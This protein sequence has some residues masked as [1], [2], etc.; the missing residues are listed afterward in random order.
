VPGIRQLR[1]GDEKKKVRVT[2]YY[3]NKRSVRRKKANRIN[4][5]M[6]IW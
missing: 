3:L 5:A 2:L 6:G 4:D 1:G